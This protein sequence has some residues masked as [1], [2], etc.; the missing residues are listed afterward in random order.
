MTGSLVSDESIRAAR[1][2]ITPHIIGTPMIE[3]IGLSELLGASVHCKAEMFQRTG[4]F[5]VRGAFNKALSLSESARESGLITLSAGNHAM[6]VAHVGAHLGVPV[7]V[8]MPVG[9]V[10]FKIDAVRSMG[11]TLELVDGD[12]LE[13]TMRRV[14]ELGATLIHPFDDPAIIAGHASLGTEILEDLPDV[15]TVIVPVGGGG[16]IS[17]VAA[18]VK[19]LNPSVR[20]VGVEPD[21]ADVVSRSRD[22]GRPVGQPRPKSLAD[23]LTA[24][25]TGRLLLNHIDAFVDDV[26][27]VAEASILPAWRDL[28]TIAKFAGEPAAAAGIAAIITGA[29]RLDPDETVCLVLSGGNADFAKLS[30]Q[31]SDSN[32]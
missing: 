10:Q 9:A 22:A 16:L 15:D 32:G 28:V 1:A 13:H 27:V 6:A 8:C 7:T 24:P 31:T 21:G 5:K 11:A 26:V 14:E 2:R 20:V 23:G 3:S 25:M 4:S 19:T 30:D 17:G 12:L 29:V 18:A